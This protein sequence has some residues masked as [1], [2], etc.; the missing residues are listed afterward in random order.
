MKKFVLLTVLLLAGICL[1]P[2]QELN[3]RYDLSPFLV[4]LSDGRLIHPDREYAYQYSGITA[5]HFF[6]GSFAR[7]FTVD[8]AWDAFYDLTAGDSD[9]LT[10]DF[11]LRNNA[12]FRIELVYEGPEVFRY[13]YELD[14]PPF[15]D[16]FGQ[17]EDEQVDSLSP[18]GTPS[19][20]GPVPGESAEAASGT[21]GPDNPGKAGNGGEE[22]A[23]PGTPAVSVYTGIMRKSTEE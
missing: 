18:G 10:V 14:D 3:G 23:A 13:Y 1:L 5:V 9:N 20:T 17:G 4:R 6:K 16:P 2:A 11:R 12:V 21:T 22:P 15:A 19:D 8:S 7:I